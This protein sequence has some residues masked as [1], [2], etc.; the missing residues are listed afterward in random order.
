[1]QE[2]NANILCGTGYQKILADQ[3]A[4]STVSVVTLPNDK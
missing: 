1:M 4:E 2:K 3:V